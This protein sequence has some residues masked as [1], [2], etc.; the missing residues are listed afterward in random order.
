MP[1]V[2]VGAPADTNEYTLT[3]VDGVKVYISPFVSTEKG[4]KIF[5]SGF[6]MFKGLAVAP[7]SY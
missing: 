5:L 7:L 2:Y 3:E 4:L 6:G 1:A